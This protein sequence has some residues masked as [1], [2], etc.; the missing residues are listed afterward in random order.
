[1]RINQNLA[2]MNAYRHTAANQGGVGAAMER[3]ASG[4]RINRA[5]DDAAGLAISEGMRAQVN[6][7]GQAVENIGAG[8]GTPRR[9]H[10]R[11]DGGGLGGRH[12]ATQPRRNRGRRRGFRVGRLRAQGRAPNPGGSAVVTRPFGASDAIA[13]IGRAIE[14]VSRGR[15]ELGATQNALEHAART[16][17]LSAENLSLSES[18]IRDADIAKEVTSLQRHQVLCQASLSMLA[19]ANKVPETILSLLR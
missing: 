12:L 18:R 6:G 16:N 14:R 10:R 3:L 11:D 5:A 7:L 8:I 13:R 17:G 2:A 1:M 15:A 9:A 19:Q 4:L